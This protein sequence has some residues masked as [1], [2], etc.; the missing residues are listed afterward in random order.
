MA[1]GCYIVNIIE[2][3]RS[4]LLLL[5]LRFSIKKKIEYTILLQCGVY[6]MLYGHVPH[7]RTLECQFLMR[8]VSFWILYPLYPF[9]DLF[10]PVSCSRL[11]LVPVWNVPFGDLC[12]F[13]LVISCVLFISERLVPFSDLFSHASLFFFWE[14][15][16]PFVHSCVVIPSVTC[17]LLRLIPFGDLCTF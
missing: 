12:L 7:T 6:N 1:S 4:I 13:R 9:W 14:L 16:F 5:R 8:L 2:A 3:Q 10:S 17:S 15:L 11:C